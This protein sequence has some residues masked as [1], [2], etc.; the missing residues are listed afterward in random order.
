MT[1]AALAALNEDQGNPDEAPGRRLVGFLAGLSS[2]LQVASPA[3]RNKIAR[4]LFVEVIVE[5]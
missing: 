3:E 5:N 2:A 4:H 1:S